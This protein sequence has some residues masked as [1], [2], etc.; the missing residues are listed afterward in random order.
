M[1]QND[2]Q[3]LQSTPVTATV[4]AGNPNRFGA[5]L[6]ACYQFWVSREPARNSGASARQDAYS[7]VLFDMATQVRPHR[8]LFL[9]IFLR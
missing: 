1:G 6:T 8:A 9:L 4:L 7:V 2:R 5:V 3:P